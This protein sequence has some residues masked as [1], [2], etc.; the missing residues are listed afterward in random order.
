[1]SFEE[2]RKCI[3]HLNPDKHDGKSFYSNHLIHG[4]YVLAERLSQLYTAM[5]IHG[6]TPVALLDAKLISIP[7]DNRANLCSSD[8]YRGIALIIAIAKLFD[9]IFLGRYGNTSLATKA[10]QF[11]Y[12]ANHS[13]SM[14][15]TMVKETIHHF[16]SKNSIVYVSFVDATKAFDL[17]EFEKLFSLLLTR[18]IPGPL[19]RLIYDSYKRQRVSA[20]WNV[21]ESK[22]FPVSNGVR[23]G[24]IAS[25]V[26]FS[27]YLDE[28]LSRFERAG[29]GCHI[30]GNFY[31][32]FAY[33][34]DL[35]L[36]SPTIDGL[37]QMLNLM[38][39]YGT[40]YKVKFNPIKTK[41]MVFAQ[42]R[43]DTAE[44][45][46]IRVA[47]RNVEWV[48]KFKYL[49]T[50]LTPTLTDH[51]DIE[52]K[53][54]HFIRSAN[55]V[56]SAFSI[57]PADVKSRLIQTYCTSMH[58]SQSWKLSDH[59]TDKI[60]TAWN[61]IQRRIWRLPNLAHSNLL[62]L[63][64]GNDNLQTQV[65]KR[66]QKFRMKLIGS[67]NPVVKSSCRRVSPIQ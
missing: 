34:D 31:G 19:I 47:G 41:C 55:Y 63:L 30:N 6:Y 2:V 24:A 28:L 64:A 37:Q 4:G 51:C 36:L 50:L 16:W 61:V 40:E 46:V 25:A 26:L 9:L 1:M 23:Q 45:P 56:L 52:D 60:R 53:R 58:G 39:E 62:P 8:N 3:S 33:A 48:E 18:G 42:R 38:E 59:N 14:C 32:A 27:V 21:C 35:T 66:F 5:L 15:T 67:E 17:V 22:P 49:G 43:I 7:K 13:T 10:L 12:K 57:A 54:A 11:A 20:V 29:I 44:L 65:F